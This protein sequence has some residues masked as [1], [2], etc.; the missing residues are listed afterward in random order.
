M[1]R[2][3][4]FLIFIFLCAVV[5]FQS[6][7]PN[8][9]IAENFAQAE[10][11]P[12]VSETNLITKPSTPDVVGAT[13]DP[14]YKLADEYLVIADNQTS[15]GLCWSFAI[16]KQIETYLAVNFGEYYNFSEAWVSL[17][18]RYY[19]AHNTLGANDIANYKIGDGGHYITYKNAV[20]TYGIM[21]ENDFPYENIYNIG[22]DNYEE[23]FNAYKDLASK[24][25][26]ADLKFG[27]FGDYNTKT[28]TNKQ[29]IMQYMKEYIQNDGGI[30]CAIDSDRFTT[31]EDG[32]EFCLSVTSNHLS[33]STNHAMTIVGWD[34]TYTCTVGDT[35]YTGAW[36]TLNSYGADRK[37]VYVMYDDANVS[38]TYVVIGDEDGGSALTYNGIEVDMDNP[39]NYS[40]LLL[41]DSN[42]N[43]TN[44][45]IA[46]TSLEIADTSKLQKNLFEYNTEFV[47]SLTYTFSST[48]AN[49]SFD[50]E[51]WLDNVNKTDQFTL[52]K[53]NTQ[54]TLD[55]N[56]PLG[57]GYYKIKIK[58]DTDSNGTIDETHIKSFAIF[59]GA[60]I[61]YVISYV[62]NS[63]KE[64]MYQNQ[65][66]LLRDGT[67]Y[68]G[69]TN[70]TALVLGLYFAEYSKIK[71]YILSGLTVNNT[72]STFTP[73]TF[74]NYA[75][76]Y[77]WFQFSFL[78]QVTI[79]NSTLKFTTTDGYE[80]SYQIKIF[81]YDNVNTN[82]I[83]KLNYFL[84][85]GIND[86]SN[87]NAIILSTNP[88]NLFYKQYINAPTKEHYTFLG[89]YQESDFVNKIPNDANG[90]YLSFSAVQNNI[91]GTNYLYSHSQTFYATNGIN[92]KILYAKWEITN[93]SITYNLDGGDNNIANPSSYN[94]ETETFALLAPTK[95]GF[96]FLGWSGTGISGTS[97][98]VTITQGST[99][100]KS[101][102]AN[103][104]ENTY[105][106]AYNNNGG[107]G[108]IS[109]SAVSYSGDFTTA[110]TGSDIESGDEHIVLVGW[111]VNA[112]DNVL[113]LEKPYAVSLLCEYADVV[114]SSGETITLYAVWE[115]IAYSIS[116]ELNS[117]T[118][119]A[120]NPS[121]Y[122]YETDT[123]TLQEPT[124]TG[125]TFDGWTGS[126][127]ITPQKSVTINTG[128]TGDK[129]YT[130]N[131][132]ENTYTIVY[133]ENGGTGSV[134][135]LEGISYTGSFTTAGL[136]AGILHTDLSKDLTGWKVG[137]AETGY[138]LNLNQEYS[139]A[140][141]CEKA[142]AINTD[143]ARITLYASWVVITYTINFFDLDGTTIFRTE[144]KEGGTTFDFGD[145]TETKQATAEFTYAFVGW[146]DNIDY[147]GDPI[148]EVYVG[149]NIDIFAKFNATT[150]QYTISFYNEENVLL[151]STSFDYD[152]F[153]TFFTMSGE[154][155]TYN[156]DFVV[157]KPN[158][159]VQNFTFAG[160]FNTNNYTT[161]LQNL[162][163][164]ENKSIYAKYLIENQQFVINVYNANGLISQTINYTFGDT[165]YDLSSLTVQKPS[166]AQYSYTFEGWYD[167]PDFSGEPITSILITEDYSLENIY[168]LLTENL[169]RYN[170]YLYQ[171]NSYETIY[172]TLTYDYGQ[173]I[174][175]SNITIT[176][177]S[178]EYF[179][180]FLGWYNTNGV[181]QTS[182]ITITENLSFY[183]EFNATKIFVQLSAETIQILEI[184]G[185][186]IL[187]VIILAS[188]I[189]IAKVK[190]INR[191]NKERASRNIQS[192]K[193]QKR[194]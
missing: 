31:N 114:E 167:N 27:Y 77:L 119:S 140:F 91:S 74:S 132:Q 127:G 93:Y 61:E 141:L 101:Y 33:G 125:Y 81:R 63:D 13:T 154:N 10:F 166:T 95:T 144:A 112:T 158:T 20:N 79:H 89:W 17:A 170:V 174:N 38:Y 54:I 21:L 129:T 45:E 49:S 111:K 7:S 46:D 128:S 191:F 189:K 138:F 60:E 22:E 65:N 96:T 84:D 50:F 57:A 172:S 137:N 29:D 182:S 55:A 5:F 155:K 161:E 24:D 58:V 70:G 126:N 136:S 130:A 88:S 85:G 146:Y 160:W 153:L 35:T 48:Y 133:N 78:N 188:I 106:I 103:W 124:K 110:G 163:V 194:K 116:Y 131:W 92:Y 150:N 184:V 97:N 99:G 71:S 100:D 44:L 107:S 186:S 90:Y 192:I 175:L 135:S 178:D 104:Q 34:D 86:P 1:K 190:K 165:A 30:Y 98:L 67:T 113:E 83:T 32:S 169:R 179:Y 183:A 68:Y 2:K 108:T 37:Y 64:L 148:T 9:Q 72:S 25:L 120:Q 173:T 53:N 87:T 159:T 142:G 121:S 139:V 40:G 26:I 185:L 14:Y 134:S 16:T 122:T 43:Y 149:S 36:I 117:G 8:A 168:P 75:S 47:P 6:V 56:S 94:F 66:S 147:T 102:T 152:T 193:E 12:Q 162:T 62:Y 69:F 59:S 18:Y 171:D 51:I 156:Q 187:G 115:Q 4:M 3:A 176:K 151:K 82:Y 164:T 23:Y 28:P 181:L 41:S 42:S 76:G 118:N 19:I 145:Y 109:N 143:N 177:Q 39:E 123:F 80:F 73:A 52:T 105:T 15:V 157:I 11:V 180:T